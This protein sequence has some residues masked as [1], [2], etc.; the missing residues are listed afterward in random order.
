MAHVQSHGV[1]SESEGIPAGHPRLAGAGSNDEPIM[2]GIER[3]LR[4]ARGEKGK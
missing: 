3:L 2:E 1:L 4:Q